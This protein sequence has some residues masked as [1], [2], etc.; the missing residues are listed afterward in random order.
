MYCPTCRREYP[1]PAGNFCPQDATRL[2]VLSDK[3]PPPS[4]MGGVCPVCRRGFEPGV[5]VCPTDKEELVPYAAVP[6]PP[7][8]SVKGKICPTC[9]DRFDGS[10]TFCGKDG[11]ALVLLN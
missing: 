2:V 4:A 8:V 9:G 3:D 6:A 1:P 7:T 5:K 10:A 11:T